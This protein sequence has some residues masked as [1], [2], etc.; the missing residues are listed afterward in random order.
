MLTNFLPLSLNQI[1]DDTFQLEPSLLEDLTAQIASLASIYHKPAEAF[2]MKTFHHTVTEDEEEV[3]EEALGENG[4]ESE[5]PDTAGQVYSN[6]GATGG[7]DL[8][9]LMD[10]EPTPA[11]TRPSYP[12]ATSTPSGP[13]GPKKVQLVTPEVGLGV[14]ISGVMTRVNGQLALLLDVG[15]C[16][17]FFNLYYHQY[18][19]FS[20]LCY[21]PFYSRGTKQYEYT[22]AL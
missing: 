7:G 5:S 17:I 4:A 15:K 18:V 21:H 16:R 13:S 8:L 20:S 3:E 12:G 11:P 14:F 2:V 19:T 1:G 10:E 22:V 9:D 6:Y